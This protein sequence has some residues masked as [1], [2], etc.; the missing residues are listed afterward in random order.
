M[1]ICV[2]DSRKSEVVMRYREPYTLIP[3]KVS[4]KTIWYYRTY[5][6]EGKRTTARSTGQTAKTA[7]RAYC[8]TLHKEGNL[9]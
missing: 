6:K 3:R 8:A 9:T 5:D 7:A 4:N 1:T 2:T